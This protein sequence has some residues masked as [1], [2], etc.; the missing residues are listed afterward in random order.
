MSMTTQAV[1]SYEV[2]ITTGNRRGASTTAA[3]YVRLI[4]KYAN[5]QRI[6]VPGE[7]TRDTTVVA[8]IKT[9]HPLGRI[10][11]VEV[12]HDNVGDLGVGWYLESIELI[13]LKDSASTHRPQEYNHHQQHRAAHGTMPAHQIPNLQEGDV[14]RTLMFPVRR[15]LGKSDIGVGN[16]P[17]SV[18][19]R[20]GI[21]DSMTDPTSFMLPGAQLIKGTKA[22]PFFIKC[23]AAAFPHPEKVRDGERGV[24]RPDIGHAGEDAYSIATVRTPDRN[25]LEKLGKLRAGSL[26]KSK[27]PTTVTISVC[28]G[29]YQWRDKGIDAGEWSR[30]LSRMLL[31]Q[32]Q[33]H[34]RDPDAQDSIQSERWTQSY[35]DLGL[36]PPLVP[37]A[38][39]SAM[40]KAAEERI[41]ETELL[42]SSTACVASLHGLDNMM[43]VAC[44]GDSGVLVYR[45]S[46][47]VIFRTPEQEHAFGYPF[48]LGHHDVSDHASDALVS[49]CRITSGDVVIVASDGL[50]DNLF[51]SQISKILDK[52]MDTRNAQLCAT[53]LASEAYANSVSERMETP[54]SQAAGEEFNL[55]W[56]GG[57]KDDISVVVAFIVD[58]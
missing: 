30:Y 28:D 12:G 24:V 15:W 40:L 50:F 6:E 19:L 27:L 17:T 57:K 37:L 51:E 42:G 38:H 36:L 44:L 20:V 33:H 14:V 18:Q 16:Y 46:M 1:R 53:E 49:H 5:T 9:P 32:G 10:R 26:V 29:V 43:F 23:G 48:Q 34:V 45:K 41:R 55:V 54:Y 13:E 11:I 56:C 22:E 7:F 3:V 2:R 8:V 47:G 39:P 31:Y 35:K 4:G 58:K 52:H 21:A 25:A